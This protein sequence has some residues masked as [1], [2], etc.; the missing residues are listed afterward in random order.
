[1]APTAAAVLA[2]WLLGTDGTAW[3]LALATLAVYAAATP[4]HMG[5]REGVG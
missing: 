5:V 3:G 1:M 4:G 2:W